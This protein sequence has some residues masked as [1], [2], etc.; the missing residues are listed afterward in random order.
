H[1]L[2]ISVADLWPDEAGAGTESIASDSAAADPT[3]PDPTAR[4]LDQLRPLCAEDAMV[5]LRL[6][7]E[8]IR[9]RYHQLDL[10]QLRRYG[11]EHAFALAIDDSAVTFLP[12]AEAISRAQ[13]IA[14]SAS[15]IEER[16]SPRDE[17]IRLADEWIAGAEDEQEQ[18]A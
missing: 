6:E 9:Q 13:S 17:L 11:E 5:Q 4:I 16:L 2:V 14:F 3:A 18:Q 12:D 10:N 15:D 1:R 8:L 7:G